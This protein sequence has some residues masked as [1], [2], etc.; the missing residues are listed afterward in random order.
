MRGAAQRDG[1]IARRVHGRHGHGVVCVD[2]AVSGSTYLIQ[3][4]LRVLAA[5]TLCLRLC[6]A[7]ALTLTFTFLLLHFHPP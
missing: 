6:L 5:V 4:F 1:A 2:R 7:F 3:Q